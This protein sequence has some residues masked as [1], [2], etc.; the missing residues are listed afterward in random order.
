MPRRSPGFPSE[1]ETHLF[2]RNSFFQG[3]PVEQ[4]AVLAWSVCCLLIAGGCG[5]AAKGPAREAI[6]GTV[7]REGQP[8]DS[9][10][11]RLTP[12][13][14]GPTAATRI[15]N[16]GYRFSRSDGPVAGPMKVEIIQDP[17]KGNPEAGLPKK[18]AK[19]VADTRFKKPMPPNGWVEEV[20]IQ[21]N[22]RSP[23]DFE[24]GL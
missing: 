3:F 14:G 11:I 20:E 6:F 17:L 12:K 10:T 15:Q 18:D 21:Q 4:Q 9:G 5:A 8:V 1:L 7:M 2:R 23:V 13:D 24:L 16:G 19:A 22:H